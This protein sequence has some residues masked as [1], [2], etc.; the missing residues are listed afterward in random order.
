MRGHGS[1]IEARREAKDGHLADFHDNC[2]GRTTNGVVVVIEI[3]YGPTSYPGIA[4]AVVEAIRAS[5][6]TDSARITRFDHTVVRE[7]KQRAP[8]IATGILTPD[9]PILTTSSGQLRAW[10]TGSAPTTPTN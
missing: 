1:V 3:K 7:A 6:P 2:L 4:E 9:W 10:L 8:E 5:M